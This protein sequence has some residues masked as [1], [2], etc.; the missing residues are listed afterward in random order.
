MPEETLSYREWMEEFRREVDSQMASGSQAQLSPG[1]GPDWFRVA[2]EIRAFQK[3]I[4]ALR[5]E[6]ERL[7][8][9]DSTPPVPPEQLP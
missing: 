5:A 8:A 6:I 9:F 2:E 3:E 1:D 4:A 7:R